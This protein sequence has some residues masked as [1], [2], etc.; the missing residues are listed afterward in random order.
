MRTLDVNFLSPKRVAPWAWRL[1]GVLGLLNLCLLAALISLKVSTDQIDRKASAATGGSGDH[2][3][4]TPDAEAKP[5]P[6]GAA[7]LLLETRGVWI[8]VL[9]SLESVKSTD[10]QVQSLS[11]A[12]RDGLALVE[13]Q[14]LSW[15]HLL[16]FVDELNTFRSV[17][18]WEV[19]ESTV[20]EA[21]GVPGTA[22]LSGSVRSVAAASGSKPEFSR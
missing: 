9:G 10:V 4:L 11:M 8:D 7:E 15:K 6:Q 16:A 1:A 2:P 3:A 22:T 13:V 14:F 20:P 5:A 21:P 17:M 12:N 19:V 18:R